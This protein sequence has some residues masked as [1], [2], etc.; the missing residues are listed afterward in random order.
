MGRPHTGSEMHILNGSLEGRDTFC[1]HESAHQP[2][3]AQAPGGKGS[4]A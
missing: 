1:M 4:I 2:H 3:G